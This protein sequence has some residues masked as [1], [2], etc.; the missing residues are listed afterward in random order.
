MIDFESVA[1]NYVK[2]KKYPRV[3]GVLKKLIGA[4]MIIKY[5]FD[6]GIILTVG[7]LLPSTPL[8][9]KQLIK[10]I[11]ENKA[12]QFCVNSL[13]VNDYQK[14]STNYTWNSISS[15]KAKMHLKDSL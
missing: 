9:K 13:N 8:V 2:R 10:A 14:V 1:K 7:K 6:L 12:L 4:I 3:V 15:S 5:I 11:I